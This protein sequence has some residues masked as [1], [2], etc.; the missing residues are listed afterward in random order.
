MSSQTK[1]GPVKAFVQMMAICHTVVPEL[2][3]ADGER[4]AVSKAMISK[5]RE[6]EFPYETLR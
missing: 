1:E 6:Q 5:L 4:Q 2:V 3:S